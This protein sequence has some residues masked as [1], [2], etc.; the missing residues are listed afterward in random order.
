MHACLPGQWSQ[1]TAWPN[2]T[3]WPQPYVGSA[4]LRSLDALRLG[5]AVAAV[6]LLLQRQ[7]ALTV[8]SGHTASHLCSYWLE[9][10]QC[11]VHAAP[12]TARFDARSQ[13]SDRGW[14]EASSLLPAWP[15]R[16]GS[17]SPGQPR[18]PATQPAASCPL[19][20]YPPIDSSSTWAAPS[21]PRGAMQWFTQPCRAETK[22]PNCAR[23]HGAGRGY[24]AI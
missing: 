16:S 6:P 24:G 4:Q 20:A 12:C 1:S 9:Y 19:P 13:R 23:R 18:G 11:A 21:R 3:A 15:G 5:R 8:R 7:A 14:P 10:A 2:S 17:P 22:T